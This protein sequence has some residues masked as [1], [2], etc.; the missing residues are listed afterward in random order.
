MTASCQVYFCKSITLTLKVKKENGR[1]SSFPKHQHYDTG[2]PWKAVMASWVRTCGVLLYF[3]ERE[4]C[5]S[6]GHVLQA[7]RPAVRKSVQ[8]AKIEK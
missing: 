4:P 6:R 8:I 2:G 7:Y 1:L 3:S 5:V